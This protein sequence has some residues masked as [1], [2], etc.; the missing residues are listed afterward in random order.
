M[1]REF[2]IT[3][4]DEIRV[5]KD[6]SV[7][8]YARVSTNR[9]EQLDSLAAQV[10]GLTRLASSHFLWFVADVFIDI[11]SA[12]TGSVRVELERMLTACERGSIDIVLTKSINRFGRD[13]KE[14]LEA[15]RRIKNAGKRIIFEREKIDSESMGDEVILSVLESCEQ[16]ENDWRSEN[17][18]WGL[19][20]RAHNGTSG[21]YDRPCYGFRKDEYGMLVID[22]EQAEIVRRI[23]NLYLGGATALGIKRELER[24]GIK[25]PTG[26]DK[27]N[28]STIEKMLVNRKYTGDVAIAGSDNIGNRYMI[29]EHHYGIIS[30]EMFEAV[31]LEMACRSNVEETENGVKRKSTKYSSKRKKETVT[32]YAY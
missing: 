23:Y 1:E 17:I 27:W 6:F 30:K 3:R 9:K 16:A 20:K 19:S 29:K 4:I 13:T 8:I 21:L 15:F 14:T 12:K 2:K 24:R 25:S 18:R 28:K 7:G 31:E 11:G 10:S 26:K 5:K 22:E 32:D